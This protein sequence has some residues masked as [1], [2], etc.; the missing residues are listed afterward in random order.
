MNFRS[1]NKCS[2]ANVL[3][4]HFHLFSGCTYIVVNDYDQCGWLFLDGLQVS[5]SQNTYYIIH[6]D[7]ILCLLSLYQ[8]NGSSV[9]FMYWGL[10]RWWRRWLRWRWWRRWWREVEGNTTSKKAKKWRK[11]TALCTFTYFYN[12]NTLNQHPLLCQ[13][14]L[15]F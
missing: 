7:C 3:A 9:Y 12:K 14:I 10:W 13:N 5:I 11:F 1:F 4:F 2:L 15:N 8:C 6:C